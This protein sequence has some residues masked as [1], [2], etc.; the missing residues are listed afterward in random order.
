M[1]R[2]NLRNLRR[3]KVVVPFLIILIAFDSARWPNEEIRIEML[4]KLMNPDLKKAMV[5]TSLTNPDGKDHAL[6]LNITA[7]LLL[8]IYYFQK[9]EAQKKS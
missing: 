8:R 6:I 2:S 1:P 5:H 3:N 7:T 4:Y 9:I